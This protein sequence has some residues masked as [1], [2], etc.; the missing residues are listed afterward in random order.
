MRTFFEGRILI[1]KGPNITHVLGNPKVT[2]SYSK[3]SS[4]LV[5]ECLD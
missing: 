1:L 4:Y 3:D 5:F 2:T